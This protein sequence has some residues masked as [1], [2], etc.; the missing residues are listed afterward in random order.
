MTTPEPHLILLEPVVC[1]AALGFVLL[2]GGLVGWA[3]RVG[4][5]IAAEIR[6]RRVR[7]KLKRIACASA[8]RPRKPANRRK[9]AQFAETE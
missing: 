4:R 9:S 1:L 6:L 2:C 7:R 8:D 3:W 5:R